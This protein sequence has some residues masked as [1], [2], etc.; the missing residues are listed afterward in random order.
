[1]HHDAPR[2]LGGAHGGKGYQATSGYWYH[3]PGQCFA[4][5]TEETHVNDHW[6]KLWPAQRSVYIINKCSPCRG[7][8]CWCL[9]HNIS[10]GS[11]WV[12]AGV[13]VWPCGCSMRVSDLKLFGLTVATLRLPCYT[14]ASMKGCYSLWK[15]LKYCAHLAWAVDSMNFSTLNFR[16][17]ICIYIYYNIYI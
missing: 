17:N 11:S 10:I 9:Q 7:H 5:C 1:M 6:R 8:G 13:N 3:V 2:K 12:H 15:H 16:T 14:S 4:C